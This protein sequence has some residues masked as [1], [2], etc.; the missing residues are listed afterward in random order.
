MKS[1]PPV[2]TQVLAVPDGE[3]SDC[4]LKMEVLKVL[5]YVLIKYLDMFFSFPFLLARKKKI[6]EYRLITYG[7]NSGIFVYIVPT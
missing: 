4:G 7:T 1:F 5:I 3:T 2:L 6:R